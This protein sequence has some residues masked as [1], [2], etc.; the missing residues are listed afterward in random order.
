MTASSPHNAA[1]YSAAICR[2]SGN[3]KSR[4]VLSWRSCLFRGILSGLGFHF[5][6]RDVALP[7]ASVNL[8][9]GLSLRL[10]PGAG[11][12][13]VRFGLAVG[14]GLDPGGRVGC[15]GAGPR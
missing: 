10:S 4:S 5:D 3:P 8:G 7:P 14:A 13:V 2:L 12:V 6:G 1:P 15:Q 9:F 11:V